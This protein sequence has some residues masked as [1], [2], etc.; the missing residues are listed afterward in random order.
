MPKK[1]TVKIERI[2][3]S[4]PPYNVYCDSEEHD[5]D[6]IGADTFAEAKEL[7]KNPGAWCHGC[8]MAASTNQNLGPQFD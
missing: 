6:W 8:A 4:Y 1:S 2:Q 7:K 3:G 5:G